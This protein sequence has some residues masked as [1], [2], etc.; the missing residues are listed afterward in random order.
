M[1]KLSL[2]KIDKVTIP[3]L[4]TEFKNFIPVNDDIKK[5]FPN[6]TVYQTI[7]DYIIVSDQCLPQNDI[8]LSNFTAHL[9]ALNQ[10]SEQLNFLFDSLV[11]DIK[12]LEDKLDRMSCHL[13]NEIQ[14]N[15]ELLAKLFP[16]QILSN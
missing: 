8:K 10:Q 11:E 2:A 16:S 14:F 13:E 12:T 4:T 7:H 3:S 6:K 1:H 15:H 9:K 5:C